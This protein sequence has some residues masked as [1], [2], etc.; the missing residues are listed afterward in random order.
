MAIKR[1]KRAAA[2]RPWATLENAKLAAA[3][4]LLWMFASTVPELEGH[5]RRNPTEWL[6]WARLVLLEPPAG[7][8]R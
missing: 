5:I 4:P 8:C 3:L 1:R 6:D 7:D 2:G